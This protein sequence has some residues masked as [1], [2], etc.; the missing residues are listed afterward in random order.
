MP[1]YGAYPAAADL[2]ALVAGYGVTLTAAQTTLLQQK[3]DAAIEELEGLTGRRFLAGSSAER[4]FDPPLGGMFLEIP[5]LATAPTIV[6]H[7]TGQDPTSWASETDYWLLPNYALGSGLAPGDRDYS[8][9]TSLRLGN[10]WYPWRGT[11]WDTTVGSIRVT[12]QWGYGT[13]L[14]KDAWDAMVSRA[15]AL[16]WP[17]LRYAATG[18]RLSWKEDDVS[19]DFG[20]EP[21]KDVLAG[22]QSQFDRVVARYKRLTT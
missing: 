16:L 14:P 21:T 19:E 11:A 22:W 1:N 12:G 3:V 17:G 20:V 10:W 6:Y 9:I 18:G 13:S 2:A 7:P 8:P 4:R 15:A 5:D